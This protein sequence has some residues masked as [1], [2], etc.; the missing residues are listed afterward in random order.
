MQEGTLVTDPGI[1][2]PNPNPVP[3]PD[4]NPNPNP[5]PNPEQEG[6]LVMDPKAIARRYLWSGWCAIEA[7]A[8]LTHVV[9]AATLRGR[10]RAP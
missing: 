10:S 9:E 1:T 5:N 8:T 6:T 4:P 3:V 7:T 2:I